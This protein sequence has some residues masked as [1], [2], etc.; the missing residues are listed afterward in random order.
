MERI[1]TESE[2]TFH[3][4][5]MGMMQD[6]NCSMSTALEWDFEAFEFNISWMDTDTLRD[7]FIFYLTLNGIKLDSPILQFY[8]GVILGEYDY[9][10]K[11][12]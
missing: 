3:T 2:K 4:R 9:E 5:I 8:T 10:Y 12:A 1:V 6:Y 7:E 11:G